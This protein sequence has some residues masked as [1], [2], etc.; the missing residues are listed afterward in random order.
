MRS[1]SCEAEASSDPSQA[2]ASHATIATSHA[3]TP[4][5]RKRLPPEVKN[6]INPATATIPGSH[7]RSAIG[8]ASARSSARGAGSNRS[9]HMIQ[10]NEANPQA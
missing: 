10:P 3:T 7:V 1:H 9:F 5:A 2:A 6:A 4:M 8:F